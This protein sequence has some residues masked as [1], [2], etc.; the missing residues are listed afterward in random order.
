MIIGMVVI[1]ILRVLDH[2]MQIQR[3]PIP[4]I[5]GATWGS[6]GGVAVAFILT[7]L[8]HKTIT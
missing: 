3:Y 2:G 7:L 1:A 8:G 5:V 6:C 4:I